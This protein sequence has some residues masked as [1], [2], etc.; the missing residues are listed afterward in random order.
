MLNIMR[1]TVM[2]IVTK[3]IQRGTSNLSDAESVFTK[4]IELGIQPDLEMSR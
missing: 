4:A 3:Q 2:D 1:R